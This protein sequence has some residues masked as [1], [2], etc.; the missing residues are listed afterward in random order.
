MSQYVDLFAKNEHMLLSAYAQIYLKELFYKF[1]GTKIGTMANSPKIRI[2]DAKQ[3]VAN[4]VKY[5]IEVA[6]MPTTNE[7]LEFLMEKGV[8]CA[9]AKAVNAGKVLPAIFSLKLARTSRVK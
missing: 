6:N 5:Y 8:V 9:P 3:I 4:G 7:A 2:E 1:F